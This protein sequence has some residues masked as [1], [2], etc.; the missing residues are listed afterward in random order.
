MKGLKTSKFSIDSP[1]KKNFILSWKQS[2][3]FPAGDHSVAV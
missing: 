3:H 1:I 2:H